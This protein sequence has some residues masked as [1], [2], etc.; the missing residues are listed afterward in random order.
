MA[1]QPW[2]ADK[3]ERRPL[4]AIQP[5]P[6]NARMHSDEQID[7][8][9]AS[10]RHWG[11]SMPMLV[12]EGG[13]LI[14]GHGRYLAA[15]RM[16]FTDGPVMV[17]RG[18]TPKQIA[19]YRLADNKLAEN[20][21]WD[22]R[23]LAAEIEGLPDMA[24]L[25]GFGAGELEALLRHEEQTGKYSVDEAKGKLSERFGIPPM[26]V[27]L[28]TSGWWQDRKRAWLALGIKGEIGR[29]KNLLGMSK[30]IRHQGKITRQKKEPNGAD[31]STRT[32][33]P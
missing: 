28:G 9:A 15:K 1:V 14:A 18:W 6:K 10:M 26:T 23:L 29:D 20:A 16:E 32:H 3:V 13:T 33:N 31:K 21:T 4:A 8:I 24:A 22:V 12:D 5:Y 27:L 30:F 19:A 25:I 2:P 17:A 11:W 7:Q